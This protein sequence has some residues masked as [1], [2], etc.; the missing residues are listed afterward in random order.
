MI[1]ALAVGGSGQQNPVRAVLLGSRVSNYL[2]RL[3][4]IP[5]VLVGRHGMT[6][7]LHPEP[8]VVGQLCEAGVVAAAA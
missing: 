1:A 4:P 3:S 7:S 6:S 2:Q 5:L 8:S